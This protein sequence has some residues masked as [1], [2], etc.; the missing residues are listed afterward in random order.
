M[1]NL[2]TYSSSYQEN[3]FTRLEKG[4]LFYDSSIYKQK[5]KSLH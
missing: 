1:E 2:M 3:Y 5:R 4:N